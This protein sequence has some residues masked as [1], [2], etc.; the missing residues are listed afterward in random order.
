LYPKITDFGLAKRL[1]EAGNTQTGQV[2]GTPSYMAPEQARGQNKTIGP[3]ADVYAIG[4][5]L[6]QL[7]TGRPPFQGVT[8]VE[9]IVQVLHEEPVPP[10][11][12]Q[13]R[14]PRDLETICLKCLAK[15][16]RHRYASALDLAEDL[17]RFRAGESIRAR[18]VGPFGQGWRWCRRN[19]AAAGLLAALVL[20]L[21]AGT[22]GVTWSY[23]GAEAARQREALADQRRAEQREWAELNFYYS[24]IALAEREWEAN[25]VAQAEYLLDR[26][27]PPEGRPDRRG[28]E[29]YYLKR[30]CHSDLVPD[31]THGAGVSGLDFS[32]DGN[33]LASAAGDWGYKNDPRKVP[34]ELALWNARTF[35]KLGDFVPPHAGRA[36]GVAFDPTSAR[37]AAL[38]VDG[39]LRFWD[40]P[41]RR[42]LNWVRPVMINQY[43]RGTTAAFSPD[44]KT[45][46][47]P[48]VRELQLRNATTGAPEG[49]LS[50]HP[51][52]DWTGPC[53]FSPDGTLLALS[54][55]APDKP[56]H[57]ALDSLIVWDALGRT[58][59]YRVPVFTMALAFSPNSLFLA[60]AINRDVRVLEAATGREVLTL[61]GHTG[62]VRG[63]AWAPGGRFL[64]SG[65]ADQTARVWDTETGREHRVFRGPGGTVFRVAYHPDGTRLVTGD[66]T[67]TLKV[68]DVARDQRVLELRAEAR[69]GDVAFTADGRGVRAVN[70]TGFR[71]WELATGR[72]TPARPAPFPQLNEWPL[73]T[74]ALSADGR[75]GAGSDPTNPADIR[76]WNV[77]TGEPV[78]TL[79][80]HRTRV[81][82]LAFSPDGR[83]LA[84]ASGE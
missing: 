80:G 47:V 79:V 4:A 42:P 72:P 23:R 18:R 75:F 32:P 45:L 33:Y 56:R 55:G 59:R 46:A 27:L 60:L 78:R 84:S 65:S 63:V 10:R 69:F 11:R 62:E 9:T 25:N 2:L 12:L 15:D 1:D 5:V 30:L 48:G 73:H 39:T 37:L 34:G 22:A 31:L 38:S 19:P 53:A 14:V 61:R 36:D 74:V 40:V 24:H 77:E 3:A 26:C 54:G 67:G 13:P 35:Q 64:A 68:W 16:P 29:W 8:S 43:W 81:R 82:T 51:D 71:G 7:L 57:W 41:S 28:W 58:E 21:V 70:L 44:G 17:R 52:W 49:T 50:T 76:I 83:R 66:D 20:V 6:Y